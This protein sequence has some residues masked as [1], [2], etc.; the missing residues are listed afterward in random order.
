MAQKNAPIYKIARRF[1]GDISAVCLEINLRTDGGLIAHAF[2]GVGAVT[3][4]PV[5]AEAELEDPMS[6]ASCWRATFHVTW[7]WARL[8]MTSRYL[9][10]ASCGMLTR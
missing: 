3:V 6:Q 9:P 8:R 1:D 2:I 4:T 5:R 7:R 10:P